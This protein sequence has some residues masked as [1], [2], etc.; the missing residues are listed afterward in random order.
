MLDALEELRDAGAEAV[1]IS[2][3]RV[4]ASSFFGQTRDGLQVDGTTL[5][6]PYRILAIGNPQTMAAAME[7]PGGISETVRGAGA[8]VRRRPGP[9]HGHRR[10]AVAST[11]SLRSP[12][13]GAHPHAVTTGCPP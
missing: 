10:V 2:G 11:A 1:Q 12:G 7:I 8:T 5:H 3:S 4:V 6:S 13:T 9:E